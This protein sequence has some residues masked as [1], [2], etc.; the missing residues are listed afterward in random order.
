MYL[1]YQNDSYYCPMYTMYVSC[2]IGIDLHVTGNV[3]LVEFIISKC[4]T[5]IVS[6]YSDIWICEEKFIIAV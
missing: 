4:Y 1:S 3:I 6:V 2:T 5:Y